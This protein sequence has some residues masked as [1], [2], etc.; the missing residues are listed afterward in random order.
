MEAIIKELRSQ[1]PHSESHPDNVARK[2]WDR[3]CDRLEELFAAPSLP[4]QGE[5]EEF[6]AWVDLEKEFAGYVNERIPYEQRVN[7]CNWFVNKLRPESSPN[8]TVFIDA[9]NKI[10]G[11]FSE[12]M[13][14]E[15][16]TD[17]PKQL[18]MYNAY[19]TV[20]EAL[21]SHT[22]LTEQDQDELWE[23][24]ESTIVTF[25]SATKMEAVRICDKLK[26][27]LRLSEIG[28]PQK[29]SSTLP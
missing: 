24:V 1:N 16:A 11:L 18:A 29:D 2:T 20:R 3:C 6:P 14:K 17:D 4:V 22:S 21:Q 19:H 10:Q 8:P 5:K 15:I 26:K 25:T 7:I 23:E 13:P 12:F 27:R 28:Q 9:L